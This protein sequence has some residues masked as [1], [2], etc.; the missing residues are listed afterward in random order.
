MTECADD[1]PHGGRFEYDQRRCHE[2]AFCQR[3]LRFPEY[4]HHFDLV[5]IRQVYPAERAKVGKRQR[6]VCRVARDI[7]PEFEQSASTHDILALRF[8]IAASA[9]RNSRICARPSDSCPLRICVVRVIKAFSACFATSSTC[10]ALSRTPSSASSASSLTRL[11]L[12]ATSVTSFSTR[13][14]LS[15]SQ[16]SVPIN[17]SPPAV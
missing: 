13:S 7:K 10:T 17:T 4:V 12:A 6:G 14:A 8:G 2:N 1:F 11:S 15:F 5:P 9:P 16:R 3:S